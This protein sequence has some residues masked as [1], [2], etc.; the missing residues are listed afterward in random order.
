MPSAPYFAAIGADGAEFLSEQAANAK[1]IPIGIRHFIVAGR[2]GLMKCLCNQGNGK[3]SYLIP[4]CKKP[5]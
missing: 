5:L 2:R 4:R 3:L 1:T